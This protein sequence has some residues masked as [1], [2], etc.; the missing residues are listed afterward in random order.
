MRFSE[1]KKL[2]SSYPLFS[3]KDL[4]IFLGGKYN[5]STLNNL[6]RWEDSGLLIQL[7]RGVYLFGEYDVENLAMLA[8]KIY[9]PSYVSL[10]YALGYYGIIPEMVF[11]VT[12]VTTRLTKEFYNSAGHFYYHKIKKTAFSGYIP[13]VKD[14]ISYYFATPEK[15]LVDF[16]YLHRDDL[17]GSKN[18]FES[19]RFNEEYQWKKGQL[20]SYAKLFSNK[21]TILLTYKFIELYCH[22]G[23]NNAT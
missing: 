7:C 4:S 19:Y 5:R 6:K 14:G 20:L 9:D 10:E 11:S 17:D 16:L 13:M 1:F 18:Q 3:T 23:G 12:S 21:K 22:K 8:R 15:A 2:L